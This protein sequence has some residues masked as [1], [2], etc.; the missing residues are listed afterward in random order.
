MTPTY[1]REEIK[2]NTTRTYQRDEI[3]DTHFLNTLQHLYEQ[4]ICDTHILTGRTNN[5]YL[6]SHHT[7][8]NLI[9]SH[10]STL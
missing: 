7:I 4:T 1:Q 10:E 5:L 8:I 2:L 6:L 9:H 3:V